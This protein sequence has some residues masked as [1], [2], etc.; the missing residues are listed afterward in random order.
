ML[1]WDGSSSYR[2]PENLMLSVASCIKPGCSVSEIAPAGFVKIECLRG[3]A[4]RLAMNFFNRAATLVAR[5]LLG[6]AI[7]HGDRRG[8]ILETEAY[9]SKDDGAAHY[10][11][12]KKRA[13]DAYAKGPGTIYVHYLYIW[14]CMDLVV[15]DGSVLIR[16]VDIPNGNGPGRVGSRLGV[17]KKIHTLNVTHPDC[18]MWVEEGVVDDSDVVIGP[19]FGIKKSVDLPLRFSIK[20]NRSAA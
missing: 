14:A 9:L 19:R 17:S 11:Q 10:V 15:Q 18:P 16:R 13:L 8:I 6:A 1:S 2:E 4:V 7:V 5:D 20:S 3:W 12:G